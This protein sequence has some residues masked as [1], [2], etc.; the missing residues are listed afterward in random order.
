MCRFIGIGA[1]KSVNTPNYRTQIIDLLEQNMPLNKAHESVVALGCNA[2]MTA[3]R[4]YCH[5][6]IAELGI[7]YTSPKNS[8]GVYVKK[9]QS[10]TVHYVSKKDVFK[11]IW[12]AAEIDENDRSYIFLKYPLLEEI[13]LAVCDFRNIYAQKDA[14]LME[15]YIETYKNSSIPA[16][17]SFANGL[18]LDIDAVKNSVTSDFSNG[19]VEGINNKIKLIKRIMYGRAKIT[20]L[21]AKIIHAT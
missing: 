5:K 19:F 3:F 15:Q 1:T 21:A 13:H 6:L 10:V 16:L 4:E 14:A 9:D 2:K 18:D 20:L 8:A 12:S 7:E 11:Y 17:K